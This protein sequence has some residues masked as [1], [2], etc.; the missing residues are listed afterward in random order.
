MTAK[1]IMTEEG[2]SAKVMIENGYQEEKIMDGEKRCIPTCPESKSY[3][4]SLVVMSIEAEHTVEGEKD[5]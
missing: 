2:K 5:H 1:E 3:P 4:F